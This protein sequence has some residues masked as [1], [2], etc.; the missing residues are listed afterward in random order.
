[1]LLACL[2]LCVFSFHKFVSELF[3]FT[4]ISDISHILYLYI[5]VCIRAFL[6]LYL[7]MQH[8]ICK[9][10][11]AVWQAQSISVNVYKES[12]KE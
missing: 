11:E 3:L 9:E 2:L 1:M 12:D 6:L 5:D 7:I 8:F 4:D 10:G